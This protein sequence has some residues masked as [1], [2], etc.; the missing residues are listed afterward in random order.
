MYN[1]ELKRR[2]LKDYTQ[3]ENVRYSSEA[4]F[5]L[6]EKHEEKLNTDLCAMDKEVLQ[7]VIDDEIKGVGTRSAKTRFL[8][9]KAYARWCLSNG[10][11]NASNAMFEIN[12]VGI[13]DL[14]L[15]TI[16]SPL[17][18]KQYLDIMFK[19]DETESSDSIYRCFYWLAYMGVEDYDAVRLKCGDVDLKNMIVDIKEKHQTFPIYWESIRTFR[20]C[21]ELDYFMIENNRS[22]LPIKSNRIDNDYLL[23]STKGKSCP[24]VNSFR[25]SLTRYSAA[26]EARTNMELTYRRVWLSGIF[27]RSFLDEAIGIIPDFKK[28]AYEAELE[29][30]GEVKP[31]KLKMRVYSLKMDYNRWKLAWY[32]RS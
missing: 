14:R 16:S 10:V 19:P 9:L 17:H 6:F 25:S 5:N 22:V 20:N 32:Y 18:L 12:V 29:K 7:R 31:D 4:L 15:R 8:V 24:S 21:V 2:F 11:P 1:D 27:F 3:S 28:V 26:R 23:R 30:N 13:D